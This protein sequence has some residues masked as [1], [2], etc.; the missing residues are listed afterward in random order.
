LWLN[1]YNF[2]LVI[3]SFNFWFDY[4]KLFFNLK[5]KNIDI[6]MK[7][8]KI[9]LCFKRIYSTPLHIKKY[10]NKNNLIFQ[11]LEELFVNVEGHGPHYFWTFFKLYV[12]IFDFF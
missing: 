3:A 11:S 4:D 8:K 2:F 6:L 10:D 9:D 1:Y 7:N 12:Y 5:L